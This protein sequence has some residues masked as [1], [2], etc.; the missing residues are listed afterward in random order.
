MKIDYGK[1]IEM[2]HAQLFVHRSSSSDDS[3]V[4]VKIKSVVVPVDC[5]GLLA[6]FQD[7]CRSPNAL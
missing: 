6:S 4:Q 5:G 3:E 7:N 1:L 2:T